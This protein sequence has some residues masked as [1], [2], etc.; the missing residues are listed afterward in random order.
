MIIDAKPDA[1]Q[2]VVDVHG[3]RWHVGRTGWVNRIS[4]RPQRLLFIDARTHYGPFRLEE[5]A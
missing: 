1:G 4:R 2:V 3:D 5:S